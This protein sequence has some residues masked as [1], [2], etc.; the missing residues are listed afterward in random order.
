MRDTCPFSAIQGLE[1][2]QIYLTQWFAD[3]R[4]R[5][6]KEWIKSREGPR[7]S[8]RRRARDEAWSK[9]RATVITDGIMHA[10]MVD[11]GQ[12]I[13]LTVKGLKAAIRNY[14]SKWKTLH[15]KHS[16]SGTAPPADGSRDQRFLQVR[17][18]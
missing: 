5:L 16:A 4:Q 17:M 11:K 15:T 10:Q 13:T 18:C 7:D 2:A 3:H 9:F 14:R 8:E 1:K 6:D 12:I